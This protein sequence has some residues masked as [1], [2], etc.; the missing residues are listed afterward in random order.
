MADKPT[1]DGCDLSGLMGRA[2]DL[3]CWF[4]RDADGVVMARWAQRVGWIPGLGFPAGALAREKCE[5]IAR[6]LIQELVLK[7]RVRA[8]DGPEGSAFCVSHFD[9]EF[10]IAH[11]EALG[12]ARFPTEF[13]AWHAAAAA[14][15]EVERG[16]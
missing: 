2:S 1:I 7:P 13:A 15:A 3:T 14:V 8:V 9:R 12:S 5:Q 4:A 6:A 16:D 11:C 10:W